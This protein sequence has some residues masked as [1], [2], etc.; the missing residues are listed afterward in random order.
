MGLKKK[1]FVEETEA[2]RSGQ[3]ENSCLW[4]KKCSP[5]RN[6]TVQLHLL[7]TKTSQL[8]WNVIFFIDSSIRVE[9]TAL[10]SI[11]WVDT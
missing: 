3:D 1:T 10:K 11:S 7:M 9:S 5:T 8:V 2:L 4:L 6:G